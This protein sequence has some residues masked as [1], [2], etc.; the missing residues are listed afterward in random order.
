MS[1]T[2]FDRR[3]LRPPPRSCDRAAASDACAP[4]LDRMQAMIGRRPNGFPGLSLNDETLLF[5]V[6]LLDKTV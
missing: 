1:V 2:L 4:R 5:V 6:I 3:R